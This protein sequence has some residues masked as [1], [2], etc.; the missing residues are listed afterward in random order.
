MKNK[1]MIA[2]IL[3]IMMLLMQAVSVYAEEPETTEW[4]DLVEEEVEMTGELND[5]ITP[6]SLY[7]MKDRKS[8]V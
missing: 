7:L 2:L 8:V 1:K 5:A 6:Y 4:Y 3:S